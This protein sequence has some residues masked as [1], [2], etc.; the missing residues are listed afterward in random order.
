MT[1]FVC[2][3]WENSGISLNRVHVL[4]LATD[5]CKRLA[6]PAD[7]RTKHLG[8]QARKRVSP[9]PTVFSFQPATL[10]TS[11]SFHLIGHSL[12]TPVSGIALADLRLARLIL[13]N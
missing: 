4:I 13:R 10:E 2:L 12:R 7:D 5:E 8:K 6:T 11:G 1:N 3:Q 9:R